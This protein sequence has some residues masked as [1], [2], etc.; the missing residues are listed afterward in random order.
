MADSNN[1]FGPKTSPATPSYGNPVS[2]PTSPTNPFGGIYNIKTPLERIQDSF[3][4]RSDRTPVLLMPVRMETRFMKIKH[5]YRMIPR[6]GQRYPSYSDGIELWVRFFPDDIAISTHE[7]GLTADEIEAGKTYWE[8][9]HAANGDQDLKLGAWRVIAQAFGSPRAA[10]VVQVLTPTN[11]NASTDKFSGSPR[12]PVVSEKEEAWTQAAHSFVMPD[13][14]VVAAYRGTTRKIVVGNTIP[15]DLQVGIDPSSQEEFVQENGSLTVP[16][17]MR[18]MTDFKEAEKMGMAVRIDLAGLWQFGMTRLVALGLKLNEDEDESHDLLEKLFDHHHYGAGFAFVPQGTPTNNTEAGDSGYNEAALSPDTSF[19]FEVG[20]PLVKY[21][22][23]S[24]YRKDGQWFADAL[25]LNYAVVEHIH[26]ADGTDT[27]EA[28]AMNRSLWPATMQFALRQMM[29]P[30]FTDQTIRDTENFF[31]KWVTGRGHIPAFRIGDQPYGVLPTTNFAEWKYN[32]SFSYRYQRKILPMLQSMNLQWEALSDK[33]KSIGAEDVSD[34][35]EDF[36]EVIG[37]HATSVEF[38]QRFAVGP[39]VLHGLETFYHSIARRGYSSGKRTVDATSNLQSAGHAV[40]VDPFSSTVLNADTNRA[41]NGPLVDNNPL[42]ETEPIAP[43]KGSSNNYLRWLIDSAHRALKSEDFTTVGAD[44]D[45][46]TPRAL[47]Y[48]FLRHALL[49]EYANT[50]FDLLLDEGV[51]SLEDRFITDF[52]EVSTRKLKTSEKTALKVQVEDQVLGKKGFDLPSTGAVSFKKTSS[53]IRSYSRTTEV[54]RYRTEINTEYTR[55]L[56]LIEQGPVKWGDTNQVF[57]QVQS[58]ISIGAHIDAL[59]NLNSHKTA[60]LK[61]IRDALKML[62][63]VPTARLERMLAEHL[64]LCSYRLDAWKTGLVQERLYRH[65]GNGSA[66]KKGIHLG[67]F[68][69]LEGLKM[70]SFPG[71]EVREVKRKSGKSRYSTNQDDYTV[72]AADPFDKTET[73]RYLGSDTS[74]TLQL[75]EDAG[76]IKPG[77]RTDPSNQGFVHGPSITHAVSAAVLRAGYMSDPDSSMAVNLNSMRVRKAMFYIQGVRRGQELG[78]LLG[79]RFERSMHDKRLKDTGGK[80]IALDAYFLELRDK[81]PLVSGRATSDGPGRSVQTTEA[82]NVMDG[83]QAIEQFRKLGGTVFLA[84]LSITDTKVRTAILELMKQLSDELDAIADLSLAEAVYQL[85]QGKKDHANAVLRAL[86]G[87]GTYPEIEIIQT[88]RSGHAILHR[89]ALHLDRATL[90]SPKWSTATVRGQT[91][92]YLN[93]FL[94]E[95]LPDPTGVRF[96][97]TLEETDETGAVS[98]RRAYM[99]LLQMGL[100]PLDFL[101]LVEQQL[102]NPRGSDLTERIAF[103]ARKNYFKTEEGTLKVSYTDRT[104]LGASHRTLAEVVAQIEALIDLVR[105][106]RELRPEDLLL[107]GEPVPEAGGYALT[108]LYDRLDTALESTSAPMGVKRLAFWIDRFAHLTESESTL[109]HVPNLRQYMYA[110]ALYNID[111]AVPVT[112]QA[113]DEANLSG[114]LVQAREVVAKLEA[115]YASARQSLT[116]TETMDDPGA[117]LKAYQAIAQ[118]LFGKGFRLLPT[119]VQYDP[120]T[121]AEAKTYGES[122]DLLAEGGDFPVDEWLHGVSRVRPRLGDYLRLSVLG[123]A[124]HGEDR[125]G[126]LVPL[127]LPHTRDENGQPNGR[128]TGIEFPEDYEIPEDILSLVNLF[129]AGFDPAKLQ[130]GLV[131]DEWPEIIPQKTENTGL[132]VHFNQPNSRPPQSLL[133]CVSPTE[134]GKWDW[135]DL[136]DIVNDTLDNVKQRAVDPNLIDTSLYAQFLPMIY[137]SLSAPP[138]YPTLDF[139]RNLSPVFRGIFASAKDIVI[140]DVLRNVKYLDND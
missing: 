3:G 104:G 53:P 96:V 17:G 6:V 116:A 11:Y 89:V 98:T 50:S 64:D 97:C 140:P 58:G 47:L 18:W 70:S 38:F 68:A 93:A 119:F 134:S 43:L 72:Q 35:N 10:Y 2:S 133:L 124:L 87:E 105:N 90:D 118:Q 79:Y 114:I 137:A 34:L 63:N 19:A 31:K 66:R 16:E 122:G 78:A 92:P 27:K 12:Y 103:I 136:L 76:K 55:Q 123:E 48:L 109:E 75:D 129:P 111:N 67:A 45:A 101:F 60:A 32:N 77:P 33:V 65:R 84:G 8:E 54:N 29:H 108:E 13:K 130:A 139:A 7:A 135:E 100:Q 91:E 132:A 74:I 57:T 81:Y 113:T 99:S 95:H 125:L 40:L 83:L 110:A 102:D 69:W 120:V 26:H 21:T 42:S 107:P 85:A 71:V 61:E 51:V 62:E 82:R 94:A 5:V 117:K 25:G 80:D 115:L 127:Q 126:T 28:M 30:L 112:A 24:K 59:V 46:A 106:S 56:N 4:E 86:N 138:G 1:P 14:F 131:I 15:S 37:L 52:S 36:L 9:V 128:W 73:W 22:S 39:E 41:L 23:N 88:P 49:L 20:E 121:F 44:E